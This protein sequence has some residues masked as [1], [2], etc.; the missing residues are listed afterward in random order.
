MPDLIGIFAQMPKELEMIVSIPQFFDLHLVRRQKEECQKL[1][2]AFK[3]M[4]SSD[5]FRYRGV[6]N[7][8]AKT[9]NVF[10]QRDSAIR[11]RLVLF[12]FIEIFL[13]NFE[14]LIE[15]FLLNFRRC[16]EVAAELGFDILS[17]YSD[18]VSS[19]NDNVDESIANGKD[20]NL[21]INDRMQ[22]ALYRVISF[23]NCSSFALPGFFSTM[24]EHVQCYSQGTR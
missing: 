7:C 4:I 16:D 17:E 18:A 19:Y 10:C 8:I 14:M 9:F 6:L 5:G 12:C 23:S 3:Q 1:I 22:Q 2:D 11:R 20:I 15:I 13:L 24:Y 21:F